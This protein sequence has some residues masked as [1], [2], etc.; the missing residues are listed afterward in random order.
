VVFFACDK[1]LSL[2]FLINIDK[3]ND[4]LLTSQESFGLLSKIRVQVQSVCE[5]SCTHMDCSHTFCSRPGRSQ[6][7]FEMRD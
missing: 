1:Q 7:A 4:D 3:C 2:A 6:K 5:A